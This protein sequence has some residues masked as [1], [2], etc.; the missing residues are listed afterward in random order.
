MFDEPAV[1]GWLRLGD[2]RSAEERG[3]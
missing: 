1:G 2:E 3:G